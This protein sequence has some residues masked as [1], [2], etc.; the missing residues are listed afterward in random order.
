MNDE[1]PQ[2]IPGDFAD[3]IEGEAT[4][5]DS[6]SGFVET[7]IENDETG[8]DATSEFEETLIEL[9]ETEEAEPTGEGEAE[10]DPEKQ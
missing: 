3:I 7:I 8:E 9:D 6:S 4:T 2:E 5:E 1:G 10:T